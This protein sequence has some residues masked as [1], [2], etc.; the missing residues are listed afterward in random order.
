METRFQQELNQLKEQ[1][2]K[3][4]G[5]AERAISNASKPW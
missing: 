1:L 4:A 3:M 2:L 5:L